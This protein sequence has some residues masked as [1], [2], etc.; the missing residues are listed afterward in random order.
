[1]AVSSWDGISPGVRHRLSS[2]RA[3]SPTIEAGEFRQAALLLLPV[4]L[5][6]LVA[7]LAP[8]GFVLFNSIY[9]NALTLRGF[10]TLAGSTLFWRVLGTSFD[11]SRDY[12]AVS[13]LVGYPVAL[14][15]ARQPPRRRA[16][17]LIIVMIP[18]WTSILGEPS[19]SPSFWAIR[20]SS[21][22]HW[23]GCSA[24]PHGSSCCSTV[25]A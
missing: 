8:L 5:V 22:R 16:L 14:Y 3:A 12:V 25:L 20:A 13:L 21:T 9:A 23:S 2:P 24:K 10:R 18:F 11:I 19:P 1:M 6:M 7:F 17:L 15:I 4:I